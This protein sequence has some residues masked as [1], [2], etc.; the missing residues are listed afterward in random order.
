LWFLT[1]RV[2]APQVRAFAVDAMHV[3]PGYTDVSLTASQP[4]NGSKAHFYCSTHAYAPFVVYAD[5][6]W[7]RGALYGDGGSSLYLWFFGR[8][9]RIREL[10]HWAS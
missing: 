9:F 7:Q 10:E 6:G 5:Y 2:G 8:T 3:P 1:H 4:T